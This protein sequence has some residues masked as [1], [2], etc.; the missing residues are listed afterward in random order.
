MALHP[1][2]PVSPHTPLIPEHRWF[3]ADEE[4]RATA[5][6]KL[7][8]PL[9]ASIRR[10][11]HTWR[12]SGYDGAA[13]AT[14]ALLNHWF[15]TE[16]L[17]KT[18]S[19]E[20]ATRLRIRDTRPFRVEN[21]PWLP[22]K[23]NSSTAS[24][25][26]LAP[27]AS[28]SPSPPSLKP[29]PTCKP[30]PKTTSPSASAS[31]TSARRRPLHLHLAFLVRTTDSTV[32]L[33]ETKGREELDLPQK[34]HRLR[35]WCAAAAPNRYDCL[36]GDQSGFEKHPPATFAALVASFMEYKA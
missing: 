2:F 25:A 11:I 17:F 22:A 14:R 15:E 6:E 4:L 35:Q 18:A 5:C 1:D 10:E 8:P 20:L 29:H 33:V 9:V 36:Y 13:L 16:Y 19:G 34:L 12:A 28:N 27:A 26:K 32:W 7:L 21:R 3:P 24:S 31:T 30:A 23:K